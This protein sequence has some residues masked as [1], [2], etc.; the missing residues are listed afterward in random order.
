MSTVNLK[1]ANFSNYLPIIEVNGEEISYK[2]N[3]YGLIETHVESSNKPIEVKI[4]K[5]FEVNGPLWFLYSMI[6][7]VISIFGIF[8]NKAPKNFFSMT[9]TFYINPQD[10]CDVKFILQKRIKDAKAV[11]IE[12]SNC[13]ITEKDNQFIFDSNAKK[14]YKTLKIVKAFVWI[15]LIAFIATF[16]VLTIEK[17]M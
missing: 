13:E 2:K 17:Y 5:I 16:L 6:F 12:S 10:N 15:A 8:D 4:T 14:R 3:Q 11:E 1:F 9:S 7:F